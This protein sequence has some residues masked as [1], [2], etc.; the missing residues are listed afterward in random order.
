VEVRRSRISRIRNKN[1]L[2]IIALAWLAVS[3]LALPTGHG[4]SLP[5]IGEVL[6][7]IL[8]HPLGEL[9]ASGPSR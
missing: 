3:V 6:V 9:T 8:T 7:D 5:A 4:D 1:P 2:V